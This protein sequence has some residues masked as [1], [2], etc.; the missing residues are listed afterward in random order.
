MPTTR[1][2]GRRNQRA[3]WRRHR[4]PSGLIIRADVADVADVA[5]V[6]GVETIRI[7]S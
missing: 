7:G 6:A 2:R 5:G 4:R 3:A 1:A